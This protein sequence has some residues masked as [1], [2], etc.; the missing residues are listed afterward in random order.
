MTF[1]KVLWWVSADG[2]LCMP[3]VMGA[4]L[5][6]YL[7]PRRQGQELTQIKTNKALTLRESLLGPLTALP[8]QSGRG[9][10]WYFKEEEHC[11]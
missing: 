3:S 11:S 4:A 7:K 10:Q 9:K 2:F 8:F 5:A 6:L 1:A